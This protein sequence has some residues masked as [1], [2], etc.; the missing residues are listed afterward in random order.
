MMADEDKRK[1]ATA[2]KYNQTD[3]RAPKVVATGKGLIAENIIKK[4][5]ESGVS[6]YQDERLS[7][8]LMNLSLGDEIP[9]EL[10]HVIAEVLVFIAQADR[11]AA[12]K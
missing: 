5:E 2:L 9:A 6:V 3:D 4:A 1:Q 11:K 8:Q 7:Q 10:Y 12:R